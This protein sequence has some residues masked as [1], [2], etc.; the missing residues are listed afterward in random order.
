LTDIA[1]SEYV[2]FCD[3]PPVSSLLDREVPREPQVIELFKKLVGDGPLPRIE[4]QQA[5]D[6]RRRI[7]ELSNVGKSGAEGFLKRDQ[8]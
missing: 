3:H 2:T 1:I 7:L 8:I 4:V 6:D 5:H